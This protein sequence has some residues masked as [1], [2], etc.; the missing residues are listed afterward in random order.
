[1]RE[2]FFDLAPDKEWYF[3]P[4]S[5]PDTT[6]DE[7]PQVS[8]VRM[9]YRLRL[10]ERLGLTESFEQEA[11]RIEEGGI[12]VIFLAATRANQIQH[13]IDEILALNPPLN[14]LHTARRNFEKL[15]DALLTQIHAD[16]IKVSQ[17]SAALVASLSQH[18]EAQVM[19]RQ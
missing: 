6:L 1:M 16:L 15:D 12:D 17:Q 7:F 19:R 3:N 13:K 14:D 18:D 2:E 8:R 4:F 10:R 11:R 9:A 5:K